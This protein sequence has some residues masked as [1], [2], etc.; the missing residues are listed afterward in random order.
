MPISCLFGDAKEEEIRPVNKRAWFYV[1]IH[2]TIIPYVMLLYELV[3][4]SYSEYAKDL[5]LILVIEVYNQSR[6]I[7]KPLESISLAYRRG[8]RRKRRW[9][10]WKV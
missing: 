10:R 9:R 4:K 2:T 3:T 7:N 6:I 5:K 8:K 1:K